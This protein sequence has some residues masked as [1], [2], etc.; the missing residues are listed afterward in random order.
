MDDK[1][2][3]RQWLETHLR[4][5]RLKP[6]P[7]AKEVGLAPSTLLRA[8]DPN[9]PTELERRTIAKIAAKLNVPGPFAALPATAEAAE[10]DLL[11]PAG[12]A[13]VFAGQPLNPN[14][15]VRTI[16]TRALELEGYMPGDRILFDMSVAARPA[17]VVHANIYSQAGADTILRLYD[18]P[19]LV[20]RAGDRGLMQKPLPVDHQRVRIMAVACALLRLRPVDA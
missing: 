6:T 5:R 4:Q 7:F 13:P 3:V 20:T 1:E 17:D 12:G 11:E 16:N 8:L 14:Q 18:P 15:Y 10:P 19:Y 9:N 2:K